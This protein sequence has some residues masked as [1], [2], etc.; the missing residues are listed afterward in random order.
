[1]IYSTEGYS[2]C[3]NESPQAVGNMTYLKATGETD[4]GKG[5]D[6]CSTVHQI[7]YSPVQESEW[8]HSFQ[9]L[10][11]GSHSGAS[12]ASRSGGDVK[13]VNLARPEGPIEGPAV[14]RA[15]WFKEAAG[16]PVVFRRMRYRRS[17][18]ASS[19]NVSND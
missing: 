19:R 17:H 8:H 15:L 9:A 11:S 1:M 7:S 13:Q 12:S 4:N 2:L 18:E 16:V 14:K 5:E 3:G 6:D 10:A